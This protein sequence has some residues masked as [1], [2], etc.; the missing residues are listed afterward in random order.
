MASASTRA[1]RPTRRSDAQRDRGVRSTPRMGPRA[2][3]LAC[4]LVA[5]RAEGLEAQR[6]PAEALVAVIGGR[7]P[8]AGADGDARKASEKTYYARVKY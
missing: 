7:T 4:V 5:A 6:R 2:L 1:M 3:A 8:S